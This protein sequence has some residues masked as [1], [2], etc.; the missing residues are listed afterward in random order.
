LYRNGFWNFFW[1]G[2]WCAIEWQGF[3]TENGFQIF[4]EGKSFMG[5]NSC[6]EQLMFLLFAWL[7]VFHE[8]FMVLRSFSALDWE[9][10]HLMQDCIK[11]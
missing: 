2:T 10:L 7:Y 6:L 11:S 9:L 3:T 1:D 4:F 5:G 8:L